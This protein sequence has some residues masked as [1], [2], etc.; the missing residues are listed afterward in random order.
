MFGEKSRIYIGSSTKYLDTVTGP[1]GKLAAVWFDELIVPYLGL[2][3]ES[4]T[5]K[6]FDHIKMEKTI[7]KELRK[8]WVPVRN[9]VNYKFFDDPWNN[10]NQ[11]LSKAAFDVVKE[12]TDK[13]Y[14]KTNHR[15]GYHRE[16]AWAGAGIIDSLSAWA[17]L[18]SKSP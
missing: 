2:D 9:K 7:R 14:A 12:S 13:L 11:K 18:N 16:I 15:L 8:A 10:K 3:F 6:S 5:E 17:L 1:F 4:L